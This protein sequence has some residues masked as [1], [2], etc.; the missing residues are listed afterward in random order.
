MKNNRRWISHLSFSQCMLISM[1]DKAKGISTREITVQLIYNKEF[2]FLVSPHRPKC[3]VR[4]KC[5]IV[6]LLH[7]IL[8]SRHVRLKV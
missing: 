6:Y 1:G 2:Y 8:P 4:R 3:I 7:L 5:D